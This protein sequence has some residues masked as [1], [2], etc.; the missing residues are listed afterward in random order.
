[1]TTRP[2]PFP[3]DGLP[4]RRHLSRSSSLRMSTDLA[5]DFQTA[6]VAASHDQPVVVDFWAPWCGPCR[7]LGPTLDR[8]AE[9]SSGR[10]RL[11]KVNTDEHPDLMARFGIRGIPA[12]K[13]F[14]DGAVAAEFT[15][16]LPE[17]AVR[18][19]LD[20]HLPSSARRFVEAGTAAWT[21][22][23]AAAA[24]AAF[25][26]ALDAEPGGAWAEAARLGLARTTVLED[27]DRAV[28]RVDGLVGAEADAVREV[29]SA[30]G[31]DPATLP[32]GAVRERYAEA[33]GALQAGR[34]GEALDGFTEVVVQDRAYDD[35]GA[36]RTAVALFVALGDGH[37]AVRAKR[38][39]F[40]RSLF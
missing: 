35:D 16:A 37:P 9:A 15:G 7:V 26:M 34:V 32:E 18:A 22:G 36:R 40:N 20:E 4:A 17:P 1:M 13:L 29:A 19:W 11:I 12:V 31:R 27:P 8:L 3:C 10:W 2:N 23:D 21:D 38:P 14:V 25:Q 24:R 5:F 30:L 28:R 33:L 6:V 39:A